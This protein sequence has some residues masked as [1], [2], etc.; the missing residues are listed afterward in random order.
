ME[1]RAILHQEKS[2]MMSDVFTPGCTPQCMCWA[3]GK[4]RI[5]R[6]TK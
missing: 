5:C 2:F 1:G 6:V 3:G 4:G